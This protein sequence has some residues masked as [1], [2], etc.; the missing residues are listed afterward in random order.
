MVN[1]DAGDNG[2]V[3]KLSI[4]MSGDGGSAAAATGTADEAGVARLCS[5]CGTTDISCG[6]AGV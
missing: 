1:N 6:S 2:P 4:V 5:D 3:M